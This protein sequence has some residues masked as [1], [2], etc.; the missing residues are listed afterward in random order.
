M[1]KAR[2]VWI[3]NLKGLAI[4]LVIL[5]HCGVP[6]IINKYIL[7]FH[8]PLFFIISGM[9]YKK[10]KY[11]SYSFKDFFIKKF[12]QLIIPYL[13]FSAFTLIISFLL[14]LIVFKKVINLT[15]PI[16]SVLTC[17]N[18]R[19]NDMIELVLWF[20]PCIF[21]VELLFFL[22]MKNKVLDKYLNI[23][24]FIFSIAGF[25]ES[26]LLGHVIP[27]TIDIAITAVVYY[28]IGFV[29]KDKI[30]KYAEKI[31]GKYVIS[32]LV[33]ICMIILLMISTKMNTS[34]V[35]MYANQYGNYIW[36]YL[37]AISGSILLFTTAINLPDSRLINFLGRNTLLIFA[38]HLKIVFF[39]NKG[40]RIIINR[41]GGGLAAETIASLINMCIIIAILIPIINLVN[42][43]MPFLL[44]KRKSK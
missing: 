41:L 29:M 16:L 17:L 28:G 22:I 14:K 27:F 40:M 39:T 10:S 6:F 20:L 1:E 38:V 3:D 42:N 36:A 35:Y 21:I 23:L 11:N 24:L 13:W 32:I 34:A 30:S 43:Y 12:R 7:A 4:I 2:V 15:F 31:K 5:G 25:A 44:G 18:I 37:G 33:M 26:K 8:M 9:L 19:N